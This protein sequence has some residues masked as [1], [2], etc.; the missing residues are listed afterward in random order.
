MTG[1]WALASI[2]AAGAALYVAAEYTSAVSA[3]DDAEALLAAERVRSSRLTVERDRA[4]ADASR[5]RAGLM[6][7]RYERKARTADEFVP[8]V[9]VVVPAKQLPEAGELELWWRAEADRSQIPAV[10]DV[11]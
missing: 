2:V 7:G 1:G 9:R 11:R 5:L 3:W 8:G 4:L 10:E 6:N